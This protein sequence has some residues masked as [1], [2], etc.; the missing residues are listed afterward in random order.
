MILWIILLIRGLVELSQ[1]IRGLILI[2]FGLLFVTGFFVKK[3]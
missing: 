3:K 2:I 1:F